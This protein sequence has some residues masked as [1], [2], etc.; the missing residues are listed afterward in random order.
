MN[1][2]FKPIAIPFLTIPRRSYNMYI[3]PTPLY[4]F[5]TPRR[6]GGEF[7]DPLTIYLLV[8]LHS[9]HLSW[10]CGS[11]GGSDDV[12]DNSYSKETTRDLR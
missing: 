1:G 12:L 9:W 7:D 2:H 8:V 5:K 4:L 10:Q 3:S 6:F 11:G